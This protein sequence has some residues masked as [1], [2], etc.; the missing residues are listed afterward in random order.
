MLTAY[1]GPEGSFTH[2]AALSLAPQP[3]HLDPKAGLVEVLDALRTGAARYAVAAIDSAAGPIAETKEAVAE[4]WAEILGEHEIAVSFDLY[5]RRDDETPLIG[6]VGHE[7]ALAQLRAYID[8]NRLRTRVFASNTAG[9]TGIGNES[10]PGWG[11]VGPSGLAQAYGLRVAGRA[12][13][14]PTRLVTRFVLLQRKPA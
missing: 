7:K 14:A 1:L 13:E 6:I 2:Q 5:R 11:A 10:E 4:G 12:L 9:L 3:T 8:N